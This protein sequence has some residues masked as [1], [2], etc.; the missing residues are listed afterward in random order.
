MGRI[1]TEWKLSKQHLQSLF[2]EPVEKRRPRYAKT[3]ELRDA[4]L[5]QLHLQQVDQLREWRSEGGDLL[6]DLIL[7]ISA[8]A[9]GLRTTGYPCESRK[10]SEIVSIT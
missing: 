9:S 2:P 6:R 4:P 3:L 10:I 8:V 7:S 5:R 1:E